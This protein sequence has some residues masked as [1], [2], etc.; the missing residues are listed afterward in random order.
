MGRAT[1]ASTSYSRL[2]LEEGVDNGKV[3]KRNEMNEACGW[4]M[5]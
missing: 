5:G 3:S 1:S 2:G 4:K